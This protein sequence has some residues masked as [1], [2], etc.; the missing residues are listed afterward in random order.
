[1]Y[2][3]RHIPLS[4]P[5]ERLDA[6]LEN[7]WYRMGQMIF[8][9]QFLNVNATYYSTIW[10]RLNL[11]EHQYSKSQRKLMRRNAKHFNV[12]IQKASLTKEKESLFQ[13]YKADFDGY[14]APTL[15]HSMQDNSDRNIYNTYEVAI[16]EGDRLVAF[17]FFDLGKTSLSSIKGVYDPDYYKFSLGYYTML[18]E[19]QY[20]LENGFSWYYPGYVVPDYPKFDYKTRIGAVDYLDYVSKKWLPFD[21]FTEADIPMRILHQ[22]LYQMSEQFKAFGISYIQIVYPLFESNIMGYWEDDFFEHPISLICFPEKD[23]YFFNIVTFDLEK[24]V[25]QLYECLQSNE[26]Y[27]NYKNEQLR[28]YQERGIHVMLELLIKREK[29]IESRDSQAIIQALLPRKAQLYSS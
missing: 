28:P 16:Y 24:R 6:Y 19:M 10:L 27:L 1:M 25:F 3:Q 2:T 26:I 11:L 20:G 5:A 8:T 21:T 15:L 22:Q 9:C 14:L 23:Q 7:G 12:V 17:S 29:V 13:K 18:L 4:M